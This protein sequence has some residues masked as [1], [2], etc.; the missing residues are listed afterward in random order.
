[1]IITYADT[2]RLDRLRLKSI[3]MNSIIEISEE[4]IDFNKYSPNNID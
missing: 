3:K 1:M 2:Q 4:T